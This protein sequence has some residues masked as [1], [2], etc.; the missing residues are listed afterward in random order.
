VD[1]VFK[2]A[3]AAQPGWARTPLWQ[4]AAALHK[5]AAIM[6][7]HAQPMADCL[8]KEIAKPAKDAHTEVIRSADL[9]DYTA[10]EGL[11]ALGEGQLLTS[12]S[13]PGQARNKLCLVSKV[14]LRGRVCCACALCVCVCVCVCV[15]LRVQHAWTTRRARG[16]H[17]H[18]RRTRVTHSR[19]CMRVPGR[20]GALQVPLGVVLAIPPFNYP[21]NLAVSKLAPALMAGN[22]VVLKPPSQGAAA[23]VHMMACFAAAG[24]PAGVVNLVTGGLVAGQC[25]GAVCCVVAAVCCV[26]RA[27]FRACAWGLPRACCPGAAAPTRAAARSTNTTLCR[28]HHTR[29]GKGS[30]I[31]DYLTQHPAVNCVSF[32]GGDTGIAISRKA[33]MVPLQME[34]GGKDACIVCRCA[35]R[36]CWVCVGGLVASCCAVLCCAVLCCAV[37]CCAVLCCAVLCCA[38]LCCAV[39]RCAALC[40]AVLRCA[41]LCCAALEA[42]P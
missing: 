9:I 18:T 17:T 22:T 20:L 42:A 34:L 2:A 33:G 15:C 26:A 19:A 30:E 13:F 25:R 3:K 32:T 39:L 10:E 40:C 35:R 6:R 16:V 38:A 8:V 1:A 4:R 27:R 29:A 36:A 31:G 14:R 12:D 41:A 21:V 11:R 37:L 24:L 28:C 7:Q 5:V 23:G